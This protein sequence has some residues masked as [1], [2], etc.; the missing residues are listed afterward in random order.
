[1]KLTNKFD[2]RRSHRLI[3]FFLDRAKN[4]NA[5]DRD[6]SIYWSMS[7]MITTAQIMRLLAIKRNLDADICAIAGLIHDIATMESGK[8]N[9]HAA[10]AL[11]YIAPLMK[12]YNESNFAKNDALKITD[13]EIKLL[14]EII[15]QHSNKNET[16]ANPYAEAL[17]DA[18][19]IDRYL[20][21]V[22][23]NESEMPRLLAVFAELGY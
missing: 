9:N 16:S 1:M 4:W 3:Q 6:F 21:G 14:E 12:A 22:E 8:T 20:H 5:N 10:R 11:D 17:K 7:H 19:V 23:A 15:P 18:D 2:T 13:A